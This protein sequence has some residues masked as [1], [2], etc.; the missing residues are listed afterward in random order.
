[1]AVSFALRGD[2]QVSIQTQ[3]R[4]KKIAERLGYQ[5]NPIVAELMVRL[6]TSTENRYQATLGLINVNEDQNAFARHPTLPTYVRGIRA[7]AKR[8]GYTLDS[9]WLGDPEFTPERFIRILKTRN[10]RGL[11]LVGLMNK[12]RLPLG[13]RKIWEN[14]SCVVTGVRTHEPT[15]SFAC[16]DHH[17]VAMLAFEKALEQ[18]YSRPALVLDDVI[19]T[20]IER[21]FSAGVLVAQSRILQKNRIPAFFKVREADQDPKIFEEWM[22]QHQP[23][24]I[25]TLYHRI[26]GWLEKM[27]YRIPDEIGLI[28]LEW[29]ED[30]S[31]WAGIHQHNDQVGAAAVSMLIQQIHED[32]KG[33]QEYPAATLIQGSWKSGKTVRNPVYNS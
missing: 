17:A 22:K 9:F 28:Q 24:C 21:R 12:N 19:D 32:R 26:R 23:D 33:I 7:A 8:Q 29:R 16:V 27:R 4:V 18:G 10:I 25:I 11:L 30:H 2:S 1:M 3:K 15:L 5:K 20:L 31:D 14:F 13:Y 6:R